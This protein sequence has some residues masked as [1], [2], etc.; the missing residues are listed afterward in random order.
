MEK[1]VNKK[2]RVV[3]GMSGGVDSS[4]ASALLKKQGYNVVGVFLKFWQPPATRIDTNVCTN[5]HECENTCCN[6]EALRQAR[7]VAS[8]LAI[9]FCSR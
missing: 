8:I 2:I 5:K 3:V 6:Q 7:K 1:K 4:V 9:P